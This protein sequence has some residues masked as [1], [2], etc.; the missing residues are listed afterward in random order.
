MKWTRVV[1]TS[2]E[3]TS[4]WSLAWCLGWLLEEKRDTSLSV[5]KIMPNYA[6]AVL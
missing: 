5:G 3:Q 6:S 2:E 1:A 4:L